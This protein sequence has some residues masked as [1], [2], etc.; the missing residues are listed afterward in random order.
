MP[1]KIPE[2]LPAF[3]ILRDENIFVMGED[4]AFHQDIR[5]LKIV[6][7]NLMP[8]KQVTEVQ[9]LRLIGN[10]PLQTDITL[11]HMESRR[12]KNTS[13]E[14]LET[15]Y[16]VFS[17]ISHKR[18]D[19]MVITGAP[20]ELMEFEEVSYWPE[21]VEIMD[22]SMTNVTSTFHICWGAQ[23]GLYHHYK[24]PKYKLREKMFGIFPHTVR[25]PQINLLRGADDVFYSPHSRHT[26]VRREDIEKVAE[27]SILAESEQSGVYLVA[28]KNGRQIF[29]TGHS[30]YDPNTL[31]DEYER[32]L[33]KGER[34]LPPKNYFLDDNPK[35]P[36]KVTWRSHANLLFCNWLNYYV[37]QET[38][39]C[40]D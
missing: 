20:I 18:F 10:T 8:N 11:L 40:L 36:P 17:N 1:I 25:V 31:K 27:L 22:W 34:I 28:A 39:Y 30:E 4:R 3:N 9:L 15:F 19:G 38:P 21:L 5:P 12:S 7:L 24:I 33:A 29:A 23:A 2:Q 32:D 13:A 14:Y 6:I 37:Y 16:K 35:N 26:E